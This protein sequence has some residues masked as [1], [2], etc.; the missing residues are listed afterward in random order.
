LEPCQRPVH[1]SPRLASAHRAAATF[2]DRRPAVL[3]PSV[4]PVERLG[5]CSLLGPTCHRDPLAPD[6]LQALWTWKSGRERTGP[7]NRCPGGPS[8]HPTD[9]SRQPPLGRAAH[10]GAPSEAAIA[11][12]ADLS[13]EPY[14]EPRLRRVL[15]HTHRDVQGLVRLCGPG[16]RAA[17]HRYVNATDAVPLLRLRDGGSCRASQSSRPAARPVGRV[18]HPSPRDV[19]AGRR[20]AAGGGSLRTRFSSTKYS[21]TSCWWRLTI[22]RG[23]RAAPV[24]GRDRPS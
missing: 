24:R 1:L 12:L 10:S 16:A 15:R 13:G 5:R 11:D 18:G 20:S 6:R 2:P 14:R 7:S 17:T 9:V 21:V 19:G 22:Q 4:P 23:S 3:D 8:A